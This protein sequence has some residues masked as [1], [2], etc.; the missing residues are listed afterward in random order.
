M[1]FT[2]GTYIASV[3]NS[4]DLD[5]RVCLIFVSLAAA[6]HSVLLLHTCKK[7]EK[8]D[9]GVPRH[10]LFCNQ[11]SLGS[12]SLCVVVGNYSVITA[13]STSRDALFWGD[14]IVRT[15]S[16]QIFLTKYLSLVIKLFSC[17]CMHDL[18]LRDRKNK[19]LGSQSSYIE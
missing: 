16:L 19:I 14:V 18:Y 6:V 10:L 8:G 13:A 1:N 7:K 5:Y 17:T 2:H 15:T 9:V 3:P 12:T 11:A 4:L